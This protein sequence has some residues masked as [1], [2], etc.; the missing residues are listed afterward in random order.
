MHKNFP[1]WFR[2]RG[3]LHFDSPVKYETAQR[4]VTSPKK[5]ATHAFF[6]L[7]HYQ[8][9]SYKLT[10]NEVGE[11]IKKPKNRPI[12]YASHIDSH[13]YAY[14][15]WMLSN[16]YE[17]ALTVNDL[18]NSVLAF[19]SLGKN[20]IDFANNA[21]EEIKK[22]KR[23]V[24]VALDVSG[25]FDN[26]DHQL[27]KQKWISILGETSL[28]RDHFSVF[29]S[30]TKYSYVHRDALYKKLKI[31][32]QNP[33]NGRH[34]ICDI[35]EFREIIRKDGLIVTHKDNKGIPQ[36]TPI[37]A[38]LSNIYMIDFDSKAKELMSEIDGVYY[39]YCDD[40]LFIANHE[41][42]E[43]IHKFALEE[44]DKHKLTIND[45]KT[46]IR[47]FWQDGVIQ[48]CDNSLQY[49]GF[50]F[51]GQ[52]KLIRSA[53]LARFSSRMKAGVRLAKR[54][55]EK[56]KRLNERQGKPTKS[57][58]KRKLYERYSYVGRRNFIS[59]GHRAAIVMKSDAIKR[60]LKPLWSRLQDEI[61][62]N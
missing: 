34:K 6:P 46:E 21:F 5:V 48:K 1:S 35:N 52:R 22:R 37:S 8:I 62:R 41:H 20:N 40:I 15:A 25:F 39:R 55:R 33:K 13:I 58:F 28:P 10:Y 18:E 9:N 27:L 60:Q 51:D 26:L 49:L 42:Q 61:E 7:I 3:Y 4:L 23:C 44:I 12:S 16:R 2:R 36:G 19:R 38:L 43:M 14:Y 50:T 53:A 30:L 11:L 32:H 24:A 57:L 29:K 56:I 31:S 17:A 45:K 54:T 59:Y 47:Y